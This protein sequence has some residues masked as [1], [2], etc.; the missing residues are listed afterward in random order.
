MS[1]QTARQYRTALVATLGG[2]CERCGTENELEIHH[3]DGDRENN[4]PGNLELLCKPCHNREHYDTIDGNG[5]MDSVDLEELGEII[6]RTT[7]ARGV[8][9]YAVERCG[10]SASDWANLTDRDRSTVSRNVR[11]AVDGG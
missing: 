4:D 11:R 2:E 1:E 5:E 10:L 7:A 8:D 6:S 3:R 9:L